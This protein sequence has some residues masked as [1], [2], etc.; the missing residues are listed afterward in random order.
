MKELTTVP[1][2]SEPAPKTPKFGC[3]VVWTR[4]PSPNF[5]IAG[6]GAVHDL[7]AD[8]EDHG[9]G[10]QGGEEAQRRRGARLRSGRPASGAGANER[11]AARVL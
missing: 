1:K 9:G 10:E 7:V 3:Q 8:Q 6:P 4:N 5:E 2:S 11:D